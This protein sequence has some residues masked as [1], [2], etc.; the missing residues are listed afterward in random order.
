MKVLITVGIFPPDIGGP[1]SFVPKIANILSD[2]GYQVSVVCLSDKKIQDNRKYK[3]IRIIRRQ[4]LILR[5]I[6]TIYTIIKNGH[7]AK[8]IFVNGLPMESYVANLFLRKRL[9]RKIVGDWAWERGR[10]KGIIDD[11]FDEFQQKSHNL[12]IEVAKFSRGWTATKADLV[13]TPSLHLSRVVE[14]WG[15]D[16]QKLKVIYNGTSLSGINKKINKVQSFTNFITVGRLAPW[17][18]ID[19]IIDS[20]YSLKK[21]GLKFHLYIVGSGD[22]DKELEKKILELNLENYVTL[23]G[24]KDPNELKDFYLK[25]DIYIQASRYEGLPHVLLEAMNYELLVISTPIGGSNEILEDGKN[26]LIIDLIDGKKPNSENLCEVILKTID[27]KDLKN[28]KIRNATILLR[29]KFDENKN[30]EQ[31]LEVFQ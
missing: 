12:H 1:A 28:E 2:K 5:W 24:Q 16:R 25:S 9:I 30:F 8:Y 3:V 29:E 7:D 6:K 22:L 11:S 27:N 15:V 19:T 20:M 18:N 17:K 13:I 31:Y 10:N 23:T 21:N 26:G 4:N 14:S